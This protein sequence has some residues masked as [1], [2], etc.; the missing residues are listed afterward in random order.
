[1]WKKASRSES[2][3]QAAEDAVEEV[4]VCQLVADPA[5]YNKKLVKVTA[6]L[7]QGF[8]ESF[9]F[10]PSCPSSR[11]KIWY[12]FGGKRSAGT[13][14]CCGVVPSLTRPED[15]VVEDIP[16]PLVADQ[17]FETL[18]GLL[19]RT[20][21]GLAH[22]TVIGRFFSGQKEKGADGGDWWV[23]Y[24]HMGGSSLFMVQQVLRVDQHDRT[25]V[26]Y[27]SSQPYPEWKGDCFYQALSE[28]ESAIEV[29]KKADAEGGSWMFQDPKRVAVEALA[30]EVKR[31][32]VS[33]ANIKLKREAQ[34]RMF[35]EWRLNNQNRPF[36]VVVTRPYHLVFFAKTSKVAWVPSG[37]YRLS[38]ND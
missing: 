19:H 14:Y 13:M 1:M 33:L 32:P 25:D 21:G 11:F 20:R 10:D 24:G 8:E 16:I 2:Q 18:D 28:L 37:V 36:A 6:F 30:K 12:D 15:V 23:G 4:T 17:K 22:G 34:G 5:K 9:L 7:S 29:Q 31:N 35:F 26:D 3:T 38:C 27:D